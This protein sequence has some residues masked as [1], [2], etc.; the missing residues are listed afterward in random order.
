VG[1]NPLSYTDPTGLKLCAECHFLGAGAGGGCSL[2]GVDASCNT[3]AFLLQ[4]GGADSITVTSVGGQQATYSIGS[5]DFGQAKIWIP[6]GCVTTSG[7][8]AP[9][10]TSCVAGGAVSLVDLFGVGG[11]AG[12]SNSWGWNFTKSFFKN[13]SVFGPDKAKSSCFG[14]FLKETGTNLVGAPGVD[15]GAVIGGGYYGLS[16]L[17]GSAPPVSRALRGGLSVKQW[18]S[19][20]NASLLSNAGAIA[21]LSN[22]LTSAVPALINEASSAGTGQCD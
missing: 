6:G 14:N 1:N 19:A 7:G 18:I 4:T 16:L 10:T 17:T 12:G 2:D 13:F 11:T 9:D 20:E 5:G 22:L 8:N 15:I 21:L 3:V